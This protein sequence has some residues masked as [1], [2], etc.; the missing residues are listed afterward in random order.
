MDY[1][2]L[3]QDKRYSNTPQILNLFKNFSTKDLNLVRADNIEDN[4]LLYVKS[5]QGI[6]YLD[7]TYGQLFVI[8]LNKTII[9]D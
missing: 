2:L 3:K 4:N 6:E 7:L 8:N 5:A 9:I 1:F